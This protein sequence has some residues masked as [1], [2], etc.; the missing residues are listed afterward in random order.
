MAENSKIEWTDS[1]V[2]FWWGCTPVGP[3]CE[4]CYAEA[5][6]KRTGLAW[7][8]GTARRRIKSAVKL[9]YRLH[10]GAS[11]W[12]ADY[13][14]GQLV[15]TPRR[16]VF[17]QSMS[18][19]FDTEVPIEWFSEAWHHIGAC[20]ALAI[21]IV[22]KRISVVEKRLATIGATEWPQHAGLMISVVNQEEANRDILRLLL[23]KK[24]LNIPWV[25]LSLEP[26]LG[27][28]DLTRCCVGSGHGVGEW[29][30]KTLNLNV[31]T[32]RGAQ[33]IDLPS[34]DWVIVGGE[35]GSKARP[36][37]PRWVRSVRDQCAAAG[38]PFLFKQWGEWCPFDAD[39]DEGRRQWLSF[40]DA[41]KTTIAWP[42]G[43]VGVGNALANGG[44]GVHLVRVGKRVAGRALD[45]K[46]YDGFLV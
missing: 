26:L 2:N 19:L 15:D 13:H 17:V 33:S 39:S 27:P 23:L 18:D 42:D 16:R 7:G 25:G 5:W 40:D 32:L 20:D 14:I 41:G 22:T 3:G 44:T 31:D 28:I 21:Q 6:A 10:N 4:H 37:H 43:T 8:L 38:V 11:W 24:K 30:G 45:G 29:E 34:L 36:M 12:S 1:T 35:S 46:L 9:L